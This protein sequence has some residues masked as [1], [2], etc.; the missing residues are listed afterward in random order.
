LSFLLEPPTQ[1]GSSEPIPISVEEV[2]E[3]KETILKL[4]KEKEDLQTKLEKT[5]QENK[6][7]RWENTRKEQIIEESNKRLK[8]EEFK[9]TMVKDG[10]KSASE[11]LEAR[12]RQY[13]EAI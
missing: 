6:E 2:E 13:N 8:V 5:T 10:L 3:L 12:N 7:L 1:Q 9:K 11:D 4:E